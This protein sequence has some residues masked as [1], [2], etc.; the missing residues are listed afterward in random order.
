M[1][2]LADFHIHSKYSMATSQEGDLPHL[3]LWSGIKGLNVVATGDFTHPKWLSEI[4]EGLESDGK[5][6]FRLKKEISSKMNKPATDLKLDPHTEL[7]FILSTEISSVYKKNGKTRK[8]HSVVCFD[9][10]EACQKLSRKLAVIGNITYDGRPMLGLDAKD[11][12]SLCLEISPECMFIPAH[13]WTPWFSV[14]GSKS[15]FDSIDE[16]FED[17]T[18]EITALET[19]LSSDPSM[20]W[21]ISSLDRFSLVSNSDAHSPQNLG[22]EA[23]LFNTELSFSAMR[24]HLRLQT[25]GFE[26]T[27]EFFPEEGKYHNDGHRDCGVNIS[28][29]E[30]I[31]TNNIC[32][33]CGK[34]LTIGVLHRVFE[35]ADRKDGNKPHNAKPYRSLVPLK[36]LIA[37]AYNTSPTSKKAD[38]I[39]LRMISSIGPEFH[40]LLDADL[41]DI[42]KHSGDLMAESIR[43]VRSGDV[44]RIPGFDGEFGKILIFNDT[45]RD[46][47]LSQDSFLKEIKTRKKEKKNII[48]AI[49]P[50]REKEEKNEPVAA[51]P[52]EAQ[53]K[54]LDCG[55][56]PVIVSAG[57]GTGKTYVLTE[58]AKRLTHEN[59]KVCAVTFTKKAAHELKSRIGHPD[60]WV[61]TIHSIALDVIRNVEG[62]NIRVI[63]PAESISIL[64]NTLDSDSPASDY[65]TISRIKGTT[66]RQENPNNPLF[67]SYESY[68][69]ENNLIDFDGIILKATSLLEKSETAKSFVL[70]KSDTLLVDE[71]QDVSL[72]QFQFIRSFASL[73]DNRLF[74]IGDEDQGIYGFRGAL[75]NALSLLKQDIPYS[76]FFNLKNNYRSAP[77]IIQ[78][79]NYLIAN[80]EKGVPVRSTPGKIH[81]I[82]LSSEQEEAVFIAKRIS[83]LIGGREMRDAQ[84]GK[85]NGQS[86]SFNDIA[87]LCR[88]R[89]QFKKI[90]DCLKKEGIPFRSRGSGFFMNPS[91]Q[92]LFFIAELITQPGNNIAKEQIEKIGLV[93]NIDFLK[94]QSEEFNKDFRKLFPHVEEFL[95]KQILAEAKSLLE[96]DCSAD[97]FLESLLYSQENEV[98]T[99]HSGTGSEAVRLLTIHASKGLEF[100]VCFIPG[101]DKNLIP[102]ETGEPEEER[103]IFYVA[104]TRASEEIYLSSSRLRMINGKKQIMETSPFI[105]D[106]NTSFSEISIIKRRKKD[107]QMNL[108]T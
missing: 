98:E 70:S 75:K 77:V 53:S 42:Q 9:S 16:C 54:I 99:A 91:C 11:L 87:I 94:D 51:G 78:A 28:P 107:L 89:I 93:K 60:L 67:T 45:E 71:F 46:E 62:N 106:L 1:K 20:N 5:G 104:V 92:T 52:D 80:Q 14:L 68:L 37:H 79:S 58:K 27:I 19:G 81:H 31:R 48:I 97:A 57:P 49:K 105:K 3:W 36:H 95:E 101:C 86:Y 74:V 55:K 30:S 108:F 15:G 38:E 76:S 90:S 4:K 84:A 59:R 41:D 12:L 18:P 66:L 2:Y 64:K 63:T 72:P 102:S 17:L 21:M 13:I 24:N 88:K 83:E 23:N 50:S 26:G 73:I 8:V 7:R 25:P 61:G 96:D 35:L 10:I 40:T 65:D 43:R 32:P 44:T 100:P 34:P 39:Y 56:W 103:R 69:Q 33:K 6:L 82:Q 47:L 85:Q 22:R 29:D